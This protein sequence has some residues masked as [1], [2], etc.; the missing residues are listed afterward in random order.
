MPAFLK[1]RDNILVLAFGLVLVFF[2]GRMLQMQLIQ[3]DE[4][5]SQIYKGTIKTQTVEAARGE[6]TDRYGNPIVTNRVS[7]NIVLDKAFLP[8]ET[9][10]EIIL[11]LMQLLE[12]SG[13]EWIDELPVSDTQ[14]YTF[15]GTDSEIAA[16]KKFAGVNDYAVPRRSCTGCWS[17]SADNAQVKNEDGELVDPERIYTQQEQR[18]L[19]GVL[20]TM[21]R[22]GFSLSS[23]YTFAEDISTALPPSSR[24]A[25]L[26]RRAY[27]WSRARPGAIRAAAWQP[28]SSDMWDRSPRRTSRSS[29]RT[30]SNMSWTT[31]SVRMGWKSSM[32]R[33]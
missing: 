32:K 18:R 25:A 17:A 27:R 13:E 19:A 11:S 15:D 5:E 33:S 22:K 20:Y 1:K 29:R 14:P 30:A 16:L 21:E 10:N 7:M 31:S 2:I 3:G 24:S 23:P 28:I 9:Q 4:Y 8:A 26:P 6:I 12:Q